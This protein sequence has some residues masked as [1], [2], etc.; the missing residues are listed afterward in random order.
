MTT[1]RR[2]LLKFKPPKLKMKEGAYRTRR[3]KVDTK[4]ILDVK[5][6]KT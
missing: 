1:L 4:S 5:G 3:Q 6:L 2:L